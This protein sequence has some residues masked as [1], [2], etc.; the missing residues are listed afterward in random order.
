MHALEFDGQGGMTLVR[1]ERPSP[2]MGELLVAPALVGICG[3]DL[4]LLD[5]DYP[6]GRFPRVAGHEFSGRVVAVGEG[7]TRFAPGDRACVDPNITCGHCDRCASGAVNLC[8]ALVPVGVSIDGAFAEFVVVPEKIAYHLPAELDAQAGALIEPLA[9]VLHGFERAPLPEGAAVLVYGAGS[10]GLLA[11]ALALHEGAARVDI[12]EPSPVRRKAALEFGA[13]AAF[14]P[15]ER[16]VCRDVDYVI[17]AS[18]NRS[19]VADSLSHLAPR[20]VL[21]QMG[22]CPPDAS[23]PLAPFD[24]FDRE[25]TLV[26]SQSLSGAYARA[27]DVMGQLADLPAKLVSHV[28]D[29]Q[30]AREAFTMARSENARKILIR[31]NDGAE[32]D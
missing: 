8:R 5:G 24:L 2:G 19:A 26:G 29:L 4:H 22:V 7:V 25:L 28:Y 9:C 15:G 17:E 13:H 18:G 30:Y 3:T 32:Q 14:A 21:L 11:I 6:L 23:I 1:R 12:I 16:A 20:G 10:I 27:I 31:C